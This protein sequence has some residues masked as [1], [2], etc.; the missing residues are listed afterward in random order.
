M[1]QIEIPDTTELVIET[2]A[3][4][5]ASRQ[6]YPDSRATQEDARRGN[7]G[8]DYSAFGVA[9][10][11]E[12]PECDY[13]RLIKQ[14]S[15]YLIVCEALAKSYPNSKILQKYY[16][17]TL[18]QH[19]PEPLADLV[20]TS[21]INTLSGARFASDSIIDHKTQNTLEVNF[22]AAGGPPQAVAAEKLL[23]IQ[24]PVAGDAITLHAAYAL[25][26]YYEQSCRA[27][28][29]EPK[30]YGD[31]QVVIIEN[32]GWYV[33]A[34][35]LED[36]MHQLGVHVQRVPKE[37]CRYDETT[38]ELK[39]VTAEGEVI[40]D[41]A[42]F[43][44]PLE[45]DMRNGGGDIVKALAN[46]SI[47]GESSVFTQVVL[48]SK[49]T[50]ALI[51]FLT[52]NPESQMAQRL[53]EENPNVA[54]ALKEIDG[55]FA[56]T[57]Q[58]GK[59]FFDSLNINPL[60]L[61]DELKARGLV[62]K[63]TSGGG[64][65]GRGVFLLEGK[66]AQEFFKSLRK[67]TLDALTRTIVEDPSLATRYLRSKILGLE[68]SFVDLLTKKPEKDTEEVRTLKMRADIVR[69]QLSHPDSTI[70]LTQLFILGRAGTPGLSDLVGLP[71]VETPPA[72]PQEV[73]MRLFIDILRSQ[74][75]LQ[76]SDDILAKFFAFTP[77]D[78]HTFRDL[79][80]RFHINNLSST[81]DLLELVEDFSYL[82]IT[83]GN[84]STVKRDNMGVT[85]LVS[86]L[87][88]S[89][90]MG[91]YLPV[92]L[93]EK[94]ENDLTAN[95]KGIELRISG[96]VGGQAEDSVIL[97][98]A[99]RW[100][101]P[102]EK[103]TKYVYPVTVADFQGLPS[104]QT[105]RPESHIMEPE[106]GAPE[107]STTMELA[108][109]RNGQY[110]NVLTLMGGN[111]RHARPLAERADKVTSV[112]LSDNFTQAGVALSTEYQNISF[113]TGEANSF[114]ERVDEEYDLITVNGNSMIYLQEEDQRRLIQNVS[115]RL[116]KG[117]S[118][119][120]DFVDGD[121]YQDQLYNG[122][123]FAI[124]AFE[125][126]GHNYQRLARRQLRPVEEGDLTRTLD[127]GLTYF[128][129]HRETMTTSYQRYFPQREAY[130]Q[131]LEQSGFTNIRVE[132]IHDEY[133]PVGTM[134]RDRWVILATK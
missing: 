102:G 96:T 8:V 82:I 18:L 62:A 25:H 63:I 114:L 20:R 83:A 71:D 16:E 107:E 3:M 10:P 45:E 76:L 93:Q 78:T 22:A 56:A 48:G 130:R 113:V 127:A 61:R 5:D 100:A 104:Q 44:F 41:Q 46:G 55:M 50:S 98:Q 59:E 119:L 132:R 87:I 112:D 38:N 13:N 15:A 49:A 2:R 27:L 111:G 31:K 92:V 95:G 79:H 30:P 122:G 40:V 84:A 57:Y 90:S 117:G 28:G 81:E 19:E 69:H 47:V 1:K 75:G 53:C 134:M 106:A 36:Q 129:D 77:E 43:Y 99:M 24:L 34:A 17:R 37:A 115:Q 9:R 121:M 116:T 105:T 125:H 120:F 33:G 67:Q 66:V 52:R 64:Y 42:I 91:L 68:Q 131:L 94:K 60:L 128:V 118:F 73:R 35:L 32:D 88:D 54:H 126:E 4:L 39:A 89:F 133:Y 85:L 74:N 86:K 51:D 80:N 23:G 7:G 123:P 26:A 29:K 110:R 70:D 72:L 58:W 124:G 103:S 6:L 109:V 11:I 65:G 21:P 97:A 14:M 101:G 12:L 108:L